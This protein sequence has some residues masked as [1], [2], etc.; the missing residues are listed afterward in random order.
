MDEDIMCC[1]YCTYEI[2]VNFSISYIDKL[3]LIEVCCSCYIFD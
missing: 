2:N 3:S 1:K